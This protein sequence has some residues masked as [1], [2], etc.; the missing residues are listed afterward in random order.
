[1][2]FF[3]VFYMYS[4][5]D[6]KWPLVSLSSIVNNFKLKLNLLKIYISSNNKY[7]NNFEAVWTRTCKNN[8]K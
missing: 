3:L 8:F 5:V 7:S 1:M 6:R 4:S 2:H